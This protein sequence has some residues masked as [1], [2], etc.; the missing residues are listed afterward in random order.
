MSNAAA[1][2]EQVQALGF[3]NGRMPDEGE[4][5]QPRHD[6]LATSPGVIP[7]GAFDLDW[8][9]RR[10]TVTSGRTTDQLRTT[11][12]ELSAPQWSTMAISDKSFRLDNRGGPNWG[13]GV[14]SSNLASPTKRNHS[15]RPSRTSVQPAF[16]PPSMT[17]SG[18]RSGPP[19]CRNAV[20][21]GPLGAESAPSR[22]GEGRHY[23]SSALH[24]PGRLEEGD[25]F[26]GDRFRFE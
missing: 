22:L 2:N 20:P 8:A 9:G 17:P 11:T 25:Q 13:Q 7:G 26:L 23:G 19:P 5:V 1:G 15:I 4:S 24:L 3:L 6:R 21:R 18:G 14:A 10:W 12:T 16:L